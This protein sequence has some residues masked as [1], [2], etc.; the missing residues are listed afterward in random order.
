M[1]WLNEVPEIFEARKIDEAMNVHEHTPEV[2]DMS[3][4]ARNLIV[5]VEDEITNEVAAIKQKGEM[6]QVDVEERWTSQVKK[7]PDDP[8]EVKLV[9][10]QVE[11]WRMSRGKKDPDD[12]VQPET[13]K[14]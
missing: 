1:D 10:V 5:E 4:E 7:N 13:M 8:I 12:P 14:H 9:K 2:D 3:D 11:V 6:V